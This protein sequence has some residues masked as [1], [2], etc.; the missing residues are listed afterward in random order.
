MEKSPVIKIF[1]SHRI[2]LDSETIN[3]PLYINV[4][5]GAALDRRK[6]I[7]MLGDDTGDNISD[8]R[9]SFCELTVQYWAWKNVEADYYGLCHYRR[10]LSFSP[11]R[12]PKTDEHNMIPEPVL[13]GGAARRY[14]LLDRKK[15]E[16]LISGSDVVV[17]EYAPVRNIRA[18]GG[19][20]STVRAL[21]DTY[22]GVFF[23]KSV[24][25]LMFELIDALSPEYSK[26][27]REY[28]EG[29]LHRGFNCYILKK[30]LFDRLC[31]FQFPILFEVERRLDTTGYTE[32]MLRTP[33]FVGEMLYGIFI[34]HLT[35]H[36][37]WR[38]K[39]LQLVMFHDTRPVQGLVDLAMRYYRVR[40]EQGLRKL[41]D[42]FAPKGTRRRERLK[43]IYHSLSQ[44]GRAE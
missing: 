4:R 29:G 13:T 20:Q 41:I 19:E 37:N 27:A 9:R 16:R 12:F 26:S 17:S 33:A 32:T 15:M 28:F 38:I 42:P 18:L 24:I 2:D 30:E 34:Y 39:E 44:K 40:L 23:E 14:G 8:K 11:Q 22:D 10:Y 31:A 1:V 25:D 3:N 36:E 7:A 21:W 6:G 43:Q 5:C 35:A